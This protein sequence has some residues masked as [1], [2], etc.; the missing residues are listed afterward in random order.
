MICPILISLPNF[1]NMPKFF[2]NFLINFE[3]TEGTPVELYHK[4]VIN[5]WR[6]LA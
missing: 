1:G 2:S 6:V 4:V 5:R 3:P